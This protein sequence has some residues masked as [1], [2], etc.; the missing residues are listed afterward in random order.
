MRVA[1]RPSQRSGTRPARRGSKSTP[2]AAA[3]IR[4]GVEADQVIRALL[5][6]DRPFGVVPQG[7]AGHAQHGCL[8][9]DAPGIGQDQ[10]GLATSSFMKSR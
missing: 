3:T 1:A 5:D 2:V 10:P 7:Q 8:F 9:L 4:S 6:G